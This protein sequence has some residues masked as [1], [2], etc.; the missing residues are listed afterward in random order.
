MR[1]HFLQAARGEETARPPVWLM[2]QA[3]RYLPE[4]RELRAD[5]TFRE[6]ISTPDVATE[7]TLQPFERFGL[8]AVVIYSD[9]LVAL[10]PLG[11]D[12]H[13]ESG[14]G[15]VIDDPIETP[16][17]IPDHHEPVAERLDYVGELIERVSEHVGDR[18]AT[19]GFAGGPFTL[20]SYAV[21][22]EPAKNHIPVR[23]FRAAHPA[24]FEELL[25][26]FADVVREYV[27]FQVEHGAD[28]IQLFDTY[29]GLL[30]PEDYRD[31]VLPLHQEI[32][33]AVDVPTI[34]FVRNMGGRLPT[35]AESGAD[36]VG[37]DWT[38]DMAEARETLG[39]QPVQGN[40]DPT[41]LLGDPEF[42]RRRTESIIEA[43]GPDGHILNLGHGVNRT[44]P[45]ESVAAFV[46]TAKSWEW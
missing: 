18:A 6:A 27:R 19:L 42:V 24:A 13:L 29:A 1:S 32:L 39:E 37:L 30:G 33:E 3:G 40:L 20:A 14:V 44:T 11:I 5:Y 26:T 34:V 23:G 15:P 28:A 25:G 41:D 9:I 31:Y 45:V 17:A 2:R 16:A 43:A 22:G 8:D 21:A 46:E 4:Y 36:V 7:I 35:L 12:Y 38:V 10:E